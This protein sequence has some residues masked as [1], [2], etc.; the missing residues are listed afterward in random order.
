MLNYIQHTILT[1]GYPPTRAE[2]GAYL[3]VSSA[4]AVT[5]QLATLV[6]KG[7]IAVIPRKSRGIQLIDQIKGSYII[8]IPLISNVSVDTPI[9][10]SENI[11][12]IHAVDSSNFTSVPDFLFKVQG[13]SMRDSGINE[14]DI[15]G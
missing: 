14:G 8:N 3:G 15:L 5:A 9:L 2:I 13:W 11:E 12:S 1:N 4:N 7:K 6:R 10:A